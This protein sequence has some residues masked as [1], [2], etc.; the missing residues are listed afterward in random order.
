MSTSELRPEDWPL[1]RWIAD[2]GRAGRVCQSHYPATGTP[3]TEGRA[4]LVA[5]GLIWAT[6]QRYGDTF[7]GARHVVAGLG[8]IALA[9]RE[10]LA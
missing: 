7:Q 4:R 9:R 10:G 5:A 1:L 8:L 3:E 6:T 2:A